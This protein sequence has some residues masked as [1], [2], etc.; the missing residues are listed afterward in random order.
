MYRKLWICRQ[1]W[2][3]RKAYTKRPLSRHDHSK[4]I[5]Y[6]FEKNM[7]ST[8]FQLR[9][10]TQLTM[11]MFQMKYVQVVTAEWP[12]QKS[13]FKLERCKQVKKSTAIGVDIY[14]ESQLYAT[15]ND[16]KSQTARTTGITDPVPNFAIKVGCCKTKQATKLSVRRH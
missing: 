9:R 10:L 8:S 3:W 12:K 2:E 13:S 6:E 4:Y 1:K 14:T 16:V 11:W 7:K 15:W 5:P